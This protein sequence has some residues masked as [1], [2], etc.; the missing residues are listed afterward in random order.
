MCCLLEIRD[1][2]IQICLLA[3][4]VVFETSFPL[5]FFLFC[6]V[7]FLYLNH[8]N[9]LL[10]LQVNNYALTMHLRQAQQGNSIP[11]RF[12]PDVF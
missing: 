9:F 1:S 8:L 12:H 3:W 4:K 5:I 7:G 10:P 11:G 6:R 2:V